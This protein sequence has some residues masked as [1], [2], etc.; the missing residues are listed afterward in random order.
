MSTENSVKKL[1]KPNNC[2]AHITIF[3]SAEGIKPFEKKI[4]WIETIKYVLGQTVLSNTDL[5]F[6]DV[7]S[8]D[9]RHFNRFATGKQLIDLID[10]SF[11]QPVSLRISFPGWPTRSWIILLQQDAEYL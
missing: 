1:F 3:S 8:S 4:A 9:G 5:E 10:H 7:L 6:I 11:N 2:N